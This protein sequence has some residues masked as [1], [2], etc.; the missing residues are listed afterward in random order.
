M[1]GAA[2]ASIHAFYSL[3]VLARSL[4]DWPASRYLA[5]PARLLSLLPPLSL[6]LSLSLSFSG[7]SR[8]SH[9]SIPPDPSESRWGT[10]FENTQAGPVEG[11][12]L[13]LYSSLRPRRM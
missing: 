6:S 12:P 1:H 7:F 3:A 9:R 8:F 11:D 2:L 10:A 13:S 5:S 4:A